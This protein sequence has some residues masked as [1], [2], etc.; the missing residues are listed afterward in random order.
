VSK[1]YKGKTCVYCSSAKAACGEHVFARKF[2]LPGDRAGLPKVPGCDSCNRRKSDLELYALSVLPFGASHAGAKE[3]L[4][5]MVPPRLDRNLPLKR[6]LNEG[7]TK[8]WIG[9]QAGIRFPV[10]GVPIDAGRLMEL[11]TLIGRG[12]LWHHWGRLLDRNAS[13]VAHTLD[14]RGEVAV[15]KLFETQ[16]RERVS[17]TFGNGTVR[18]EGLLVTQSDRWMAGWRVEMYG[19]VALA[20]A[21]SPG[22]ISTGVWVL[23][24]G[25]GAF[26]PRQDAGADLKG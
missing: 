19:G 5:T 9:E 3:N 13:V 22:S 18:Y 10:L 24:D 1:K 7:M 4:V 12:L 23:M 14:S 6:Q 8:R 16:A 26:D 20:D 15:K 2:F 17:N 11:F 21:R 25:A